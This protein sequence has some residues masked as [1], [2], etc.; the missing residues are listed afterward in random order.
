MKIL[1]T[2]SP[3]LMHYLTFICQKHSILHQLYASSAQYNHY[4]NQS[5]VTSRMR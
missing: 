2:V 5:Q 4:I 1:N 3:I